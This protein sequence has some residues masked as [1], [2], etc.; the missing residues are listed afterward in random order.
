M[1]EGANQNAEPSISRAPILSFVAGKFST[2]RSDSC[3]WL[4]NLTLRCLEG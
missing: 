1:N 4:L 2:Q 3:H